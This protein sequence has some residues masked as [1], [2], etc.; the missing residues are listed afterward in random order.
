MASCET[1]D[2]AAV[3]VGKGYAA[4]IVV[5]TFK[6]DKAYNIGHG[7][8]GVPCPHTTGKVDSCLNC[9]LCLNANKLKNEK[10]VE[11]IK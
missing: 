6:S 9:K 3:M 2:Q 4:A 7:L 11:R 1:V 5:D 8:K 10:P